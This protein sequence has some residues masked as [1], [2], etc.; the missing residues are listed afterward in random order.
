MQD[1]LLQKFVT[2]NTLEIHLS[3]RFQN[4][5]FDNL[6]DDFRKKIYSYLFSNYVQEWDSAWTEA[7]FIYRLRKKTLGHF[8]KELFDLTFDQKQPILDK[9]GKNIE[10]V[11]D[12]LNIKNTNDLVKSCY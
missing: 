2:A 3:T 5:I 8:K 12:K 6:P 7:Q 10:A 11:F 9:F 4:I 1:N